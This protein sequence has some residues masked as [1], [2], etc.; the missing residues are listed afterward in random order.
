MHVLNS[1]KLSG[2]EA[3]HFTGNMNNNH[4]FNIK[5]ILQFNLDNNNL[6]NLTVGVQNLGVWFFVMF[7]ICSKL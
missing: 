1:T 6:P 5:I 2:V 3:T 7:E 4:V